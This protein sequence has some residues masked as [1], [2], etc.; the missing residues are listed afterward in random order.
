ML[1][2]DV[3]VVLR[4]YFVPVFSRRGPFVR[5]LPCVYLFYPDKDKSGVFCVRQEIKAGDAS[6][7]PSS[8]IFIQICT[9]LSG[10][11]A[12]HD[13][14]YGGFQCQLMIL[15]LWLTL[16]GDRA[17]AEHDPVSLEHG[18]SMWVSFKE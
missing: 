14:W 4:G 1:L 12:V 7:N 16:R 5:I 6:P 9:D 13:R 18:D 10:S 8:S 17:G 2:L 15:G 3:K 11:H